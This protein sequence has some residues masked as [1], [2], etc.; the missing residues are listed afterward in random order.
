MNKNRKGFTIVELVIVIAIIAILAAVLI[1]TFASLIAKANVSAD[2]QLVRNL[3]TALTTEKAGG[4]NNKTMNDALKMAKNAGYDIDRIVSKSGNNIGWDSKNDRFVL[5]DANNDTYIYPTDAGSNAQKIQNAVDYFVISK[6][7]PE[8]A[9]QKYSIYLSKDATLADGTVTVSVGFDAGENENVTAVNYTSDATQDVIIRTNSTNTVLTVNA[10]NSTVKHYDVAG[11][12]LINAVASKSYHEFGEVQG[13]IEL[14]DGRVVMESGS[15]ASAIQVTA[16]A[17]DVSKGNATVAVDNT[18]APTVAVVVPAEVKTALETKGGDNK[19]NASNDSVIT[20][21]T[22]IENMGK[23]AGGLG[24][25]DSPYLISTNEHFKN[26]MQGTADN[27]LYYKLIAD[28]EA[29]K[30]FT[31]ESGNHVISKLT[32]SEL[33]GANHTV[34]ITDKSHLF[35]YVQSSEIKNLKAFVENNMAFY[36]AATTF[37]NVDLFGKINTTSGNEGIYVIYATPMANKATLTYIDCDCT[38]DFT[39]DG[40]KDSYNSVF[41][42]YAYRDGATTVLNYTNCTYSGTFVSGKAAMFLGNNSANEGKVTVNVNNCEN[43]GI[44]QSTLTEGYYWNSYVA[45]GIENKATAKSFM[46]NSVIL[47][48]VKLTESNIAEPMGTGFVQGPN[49]ANLKL[50]LNADGTFT[51]T[52]SEN[53]NVAYYEVSVG[54]YSDWNEGG[55]L[56]QK[57]KEKLDKSSFNNGTKT[58]TLKKLAFVDKAWVDANSSAT[59]KTYGEG[60]YAYTVYTL[61]GTEYYYL[62]D[63]TN[64][65]LGGKAKDAQMINV[66]CFDAKGNLIASV[67]LS[68]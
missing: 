62:P 14:A 54:L 10:K 13:N 9:K 29:S 3:N 68:K 6:T 27:K 12:V 31:A 38:V 22:T 21:E 46:A 20:D 63:F 36:A 48:G 25:K 41:T 53:T 44:I 45:T 30:N 67:S 66:S 18:A 43:K 35:Y 4:E 51:V 11:K 59:A 28:I 19:I 40:T 34:T 49:D 17:D 55:T 2:T 26:I 1:P 5:I 61:N 50:V 7:I 32:Y 37:N 56:V 64:A 60:D 16:T 33:D 15:K 39:S 57:V 23:F 65:N 24:T 47:N 42:G 58:T 52:A 8:T